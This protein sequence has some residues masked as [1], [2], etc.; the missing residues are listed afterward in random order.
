M[1]PKSHAAMDTTKPPPLG[2]GVYADV[3]L[4]FTTHA[5]RNRAGERVG[6]EGE[7]IALALANE[8]KTKHGIT[9]FL[10]TM[11]QPGQ[12]PK[13]ASGRCRC[14]RRRQGAYGRLGRRISAP[15]SALQR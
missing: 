4:S 7:K 15:T 1:P 2:K 13:V 9:A 12:A 6:R 10:T 5:E 3:A 11:L 8:L 14:H